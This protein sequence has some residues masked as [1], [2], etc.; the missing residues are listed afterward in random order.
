MAPLR[1]VDAMRRAIVLSAFG[2]GSASPNPPVGCVILDRFGASVGEGYHLRKGESH[3]EVNA[4]AAAGPRAAG[5][6]AAVTLEPCNHFGRTP[7]CHQALLDAGIARVLIALLDP[8]SRGEGGA[9]RLRLA[10]VEVEVGLLADEAH[11]VLAPWLDALQRGRPWATWIY[12]HGP[13]GPRPCPEDVL[14]QFACGVDAVVDSARR[15]TEGRRGA[16]GMETFSLPT[17]PLS[18]GP[19]QVL[20]AL[21]DGGVRSVLLHLDHESVLPYIEQA[22]LDEVVVHVPTPPPSVAPSSS[23]GGDLRL[24]PSGFGISAIERRGSGL[25]VRA[26]RN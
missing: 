13:D 24:V 18:S 8:T 9:A 17:P 12:E 6:T 25:L 7:P 20:T 4:L 15:V 21:Q 16:H 2:L 11:I 1:H 5:G 22:L 19:A 3:A 26:R 14:S 23:P 10:G